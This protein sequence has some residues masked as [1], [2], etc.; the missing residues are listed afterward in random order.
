MGSSFVAAGLSLWAHSYDKK[1]CHLYNATTWIC[2]GVWG[3][4]QPAINVP[5]IKVING[6][7]P[8]IGC[9]TN[10]IYHS[11]KLTEIYRKREKDDKKVNTKPK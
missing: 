6:L 2:A 11:M 1:T 8:L 9:V 3:L 5:V 7:M 4:T 10:L